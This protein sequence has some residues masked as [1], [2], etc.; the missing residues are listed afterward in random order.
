MNVSSVSPGSKILFD[1]FRRDKWGNFYNDKTGV[2]RHGTLVRV[3]PNCEMAI[4]RTEQGVAEVFH[5]R[6][7]DVYV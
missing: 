4:I 1:S 3:L 7:I 6:S 2:K 5:Y